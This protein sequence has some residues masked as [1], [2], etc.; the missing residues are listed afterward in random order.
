M[1]KPVALNDLALQKSLCRKCLILSTFQLSFNEQDFASQKLAQVWEISK[2]LMNFRK[3]MLLLIITFKNRTN[4]KEQSS[5]LFL[6]DSSE[7]LNTFLLFTID[8]LLQF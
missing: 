6:E 3:I 8:L 2:H 5:E 7:L 1:N 4:H